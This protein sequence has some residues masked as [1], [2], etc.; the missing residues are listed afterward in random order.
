MEKAKGAQGS[1]SN[2]YEVRSRPSTTPTLRDLGISRDQFSRWQKLAAVRQAWGTELAKV[3]APEGNRNAAKGEEENKPRNT[4]IDPGASETADYT[5]ARLARD[6]RETVLA[7]LGP[8]LRH[9]DVEAAKKTL[10]LL[11]GCLP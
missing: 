7:A 9:G 1:G 5:R 8:D 11:L 3:G 2:Q 4:R 6:L 10:R